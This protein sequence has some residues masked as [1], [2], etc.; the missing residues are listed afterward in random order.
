MYV[1]FKHEI[2]QICLERMA[3]SSKKIN[4]IVK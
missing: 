1:Y 3:N 2:D 4:W